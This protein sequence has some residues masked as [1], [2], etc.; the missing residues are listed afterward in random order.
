VLKKNEQF[1]AIAP[2]DTRSYSDC[3]RFSSGYAEIDKMETAAKQ[4]LT[5]QEF[6]V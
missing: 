6:W 4:Q 2:C 1:S 5:A 3:L